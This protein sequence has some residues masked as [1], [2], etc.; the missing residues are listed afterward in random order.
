V[1]GK[2]I[3]QTGGHGQY[4]HVI[5]DVRPLAQH[6]SDGKS[7]VFTDASSGQHIPKHFVRHI[8]AGLADAVKSG[9]IA[10]FPVLGVE[11]VLTGGSTHEVDS[12]EMAYRAAASIAMRTALPR[13]KPRL[14]EPTMK[15]EVVCPEEFTGTVHGDLTGRRGQVNEIALGESGYQKIT[16]EVPLASMFGYS[17]DLR[18]KTQ[19]RATYTME[20]ASY[21]EV[22]REYA[23]E[24]AAKM[25]GKLV[26]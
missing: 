14:L 21:V 13:C 18:N 26:D 24:I 7:F 12:S 19:G 2:Y 9:V 1:E 17:T 3:K 10:G 16:G 4:G 23:A 15:L 5:I 20:F 8:E 11:V 25:G 6:V 22:P